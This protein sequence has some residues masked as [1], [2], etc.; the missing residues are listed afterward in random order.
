MKWRIKLL[1]FVL[2]VFLFAVSCDKDNPPPVSD[3]IDFSKCVLPGED[4]KLE[5]VT[6]N[7][8]KFPQSGDETMK[9]V[10]K[11]L[12]QMDADVIALQEI[13]SAENLKLLADRLPGWNFLFSPKKTWIMSLAYLYKTSEIK[14]DETETEALFT[15]DSYSFPRPPL[16]IKITHIPTGENLY[17]INNHLKC[18]DGADNEARRRSASEKLKEYIDSNLPDA[19][20]IVAGDMN[21][22]I[23]EE[24]EADNVFWNF[25]TD[26]S[27]YRFAD[28]SIATGTPAHWSYPSY[29]S[30][31]DHLLIT[32]E[33]F[34]FVDTVLT[35][36]ADVCE[37]E[38]SKVASD[39]R[40]V[41]LVLF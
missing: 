2:P 33:C 29:P 22:E 17:I 14:L 6:F 41:E 13:S 5:V 23:A 3:G 37:P 19:K 39:H 36:R 31:I 11:L 10:S 1:L 8:E 25:I 20:V 4:D 18:C 27:N 7:I 38:Y 30:H 32:N 24:K 15:D 16:K 21:N 26:T 34:N 28:M 35:I 40:P 12:S 9:Y